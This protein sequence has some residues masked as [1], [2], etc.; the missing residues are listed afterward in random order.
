MD[1]RRREYRRIDTSTG[2]SWDPR[3]RGEIEGFD[4]REVP[5]ESYSHGEDA[6]TQVRE[7]ELCST[8]FG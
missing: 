6:S 5:Q 7:S 3:E 1:R 2:Q 4:D 8:E